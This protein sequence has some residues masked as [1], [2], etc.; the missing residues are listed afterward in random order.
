MVFSSVSFL[1]IFLPLT[2]VLYYLSKN[3]TWRN[4]V[5]LIA[6]LLFYS[7]GEAIYIFAMVGVTLID[8]VFG[9]WIGKT[10]KA[11][12]RRT[13]LIVC[14]I[15]NLIPLLTFKY[16]NFFASQ[17]AQL[18]HIPFYRLAAAMPLGI[19]FFTFQS[20]S[21]T[22]DVYR[23]NATMQKNYAY[24]LLYVSMFPQLIAGPIVRY[25]DVELEL[26]ARKET[27]ENF[28]QG[29]FRFAVGFAK[30]IILAN[31][32]G[33]L[34]DFI[35]SNQTTTITV[36]GAWIG[37]VMSGLQLYFDF[38]G[39]SDMAIGL[40]LM[41]GF[42]FKENFNYPFIARSVTDFWHRWHISMSSWFRDYMMYP[43]VRSKLFIRFSRFIR[44]R[45]GA[46]LGNL[47]PSSVATLFTFA[48]VGLWHGAGWNFMLWGLF[49]GVLLVM[50]K[51]LKKTR[52]NL[53]RIPVVSVLVTFI[54]LRIG[55]VFSECTTLSQIGH[56]FSVLFGGSGAKFALN[57]QELSAV[58][59]IF[60]LI[61]VLFVAMT[62]YPAM[63]CRRLLGKG[64]AYQGLRAAWT[65]VLICASYT[66]LLGQSYNAFLYFRF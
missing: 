55:R 42:H 43:L 25:S 2:L 40:G 9:L 64:K 44:N 31:Y 53:E 16:Y 7:W 24:V 47:I 65:A 57:I 27:L 39:Y 19:S 5:L 29:G 22:I 51:F 59:D 49:N 1:G 15:L 58:N 6:S 41:F 35:M 48:M 45:A 50:E 36:S 66:L 33:Q 28:A 13:L 62:P 18:L 23:R 4:A 11:A 26:T 52:F 63:L 46:S 30:K 32:T 17:L 54:V 34:V 8:Y 14:V 56:Y 61:P 12:A 60:W 37:I 38:S 3:R 20:L 21:Y 10:E